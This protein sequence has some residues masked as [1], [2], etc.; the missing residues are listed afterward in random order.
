MTGQRRH[1]PLQEEEELASSRGPEKKELKGIMLTS[2]RIEKISELEN[3][4]GKIKE[5]KERQK[6]SKMT[7]P[8]NDLAG[9]M[10]KK[11]ENR[12][13]LTPDKMK[14]ESQEK[15]PVV[16]ARKKDTI[17]KLHQGKPIH[18]RQSK[19][20]TEELPIFTGDLMSRVEKAISIEE[21]VK[22][23]PSSSAKKP[24]YQ[25]QSQQKKEEELQKSA[26]REPYEI[27]KMPECDSPTLAGEVKRAEARGSSKMAS[28]EKKSIQP[29]SQ[30]AS[31][32]QKKFEKEITGESSSFNN[33]NELVFAEKMP[34]RENPVGNGQDEDSK[35]EESSS[36]NGRQKKK[37]SSLKIVRKKPTKKAT[38]KE[39]N[40]EYYEQPGNFS[41]SE[42][43][44]I[45]EGNALIV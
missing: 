39:R 30:N 12:S 19:N 27:Q 14:P 26:N 10:R 43:N 22:K 34:E 31:E 8:P 11:E 20:Y 15:N 1:G 2:E 33:Q 45:I 3:L 25:N 32:N 4:L 17:E 42:N 29:D 18:R 16:P 44:G 28:S 21:K 40:E 23:S 5:K 7:K 35:T 6:E 24:N 13:S 37:V 38:I 41:F 9:S 36:V